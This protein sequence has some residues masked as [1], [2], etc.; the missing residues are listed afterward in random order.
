MPGI[1]DPG[2]DTLALHAGA[3]P[4]PSTGARALPIHLSTSF[5]FES[6]EHAASLFNLERSGHVYSRLSNPTTAVLEERLAALE[7]AVGGIATASGQAALHLAV[8]TLA[9]AGSH[10]VASSALYGGSHNLLHYTLRRF[11]IE[12]TFVRP[13]DIDG[14]R[15][16]IRPTTR[17]LL[18]ETLGNPGLDVLDIP[19]VSAIAHDHGL[20]LLVDSTFTTPWLMR[21][22]DHGADLVF[23]SATKFLCGHGTVVGGV[24]VDGGRFDWSASPRFPELNEPYAGFHG[25]VFS[26]E[27][28]DGAFLLRARREGLRDFGA[29]MSPH[30]AWLIL[31]GIE[32][33]PLRM[34]RHI[35]NTRQVVQC[36]AAH[37]M[38]AGV[39]YPELDSHPDQALARRLLPK[40]CGAVFSFDL[41]GGRAQGRA[42]IEALK[43]F[44]HLANVGD[45]RS[46]VIHPAST[47]HFRMDDAAL[48]QA[49]IGPGTIR[50]SIGLEDPADL[51]D[52]LKRA[53]KAAEK[54]A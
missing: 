46:L 33:L 4:D 24:L 47:T 21:P 7:G 42:F 36:L 1:S 30:T 25:M 41:K 31:Q 44:S 40:G 45:C 15:A 14:W 5:V 51:I 26:E 48:A 35:E 39:A 12:T 3:G 6:T 9:G 17:L 37:P 52:D 53:L 18:G 54:A 22:L 29:C 20:P 27:S 16:A 2:F 13:R 43:L 8:A 28:S 38:V 34:A 32:T 49:G 50:L 11:G 19:T 10:I 23:H